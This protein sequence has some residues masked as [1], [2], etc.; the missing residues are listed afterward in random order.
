[1]VRDSEKC[2]KQNKSKSLCFIRNNYQN[3][4]FLSL[5]VQTPAMGKQ[6]FLFAKRS[7]RA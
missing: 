6:V 3:Y 7:L 4:K 2:L 5:R 1:M